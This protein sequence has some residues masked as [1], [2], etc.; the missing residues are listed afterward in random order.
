M[1]TEKIKIFSDST[2]DLSPEL[3]EE[4]DIEITPL[5]VTFDEEVY[6]DGVEINP[7]KLYQK[8]DEYDLLPKT[9]AVSPADFIEAFKPYIEDGYNILYIGLSSKV[10]S[11]FQNALMASKQFP[12]GR[13]EL[14]DSQNLSTGI[15]LL[16]LRAVDYINNGLEL[17]EVAGKLRKDREKVRTQFIIDTLDY[18]HKGGRCN[19]VQR[20]LGSMLKIRPVVEVVDGSMILGNKLRGSWSKVLKRMLKDIM[21]KKDEIDTDR[22]FVTHSMVEEDAQWIKEEF[23]KKTYI[24]EVI[25]T[26]TG[27]VISSHCGPNTMGIVYIAK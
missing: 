16:V 17:E 9:S 7:E 23:E 22:L 6:K 8:V 24:E 27:S 15:G 14:V 20:F 2:C 18:L 11:T 19:S 25:I 10:S 12:E 5:Y 13:I 1:A 21:A 3:I 26:E 4:H